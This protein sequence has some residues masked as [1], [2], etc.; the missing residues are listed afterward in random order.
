[1]FEVNQ[2]ASGM[3][4]SILIVFIQLSTLTV[5]SQ[6]FSGNYHSEPPLYEFDHLKIKHHH[7]PHHKYEG[8]LSVKAFTTTMMLWEVDAKMIT[9]DRAKF[10]IE[11]F[12][13]DEEIQTVYE[14]KIELDGIE[15]DYILL[16]YEDQKG[17]GCFLAVEEVFEDATEEDLLAIKTFRLVKH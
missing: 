10:F 8:D 17:K 4:K 9:G 6:F 14:F 3:K 15:E 12:G 7:S 5:F 1:M 2:I 16:G 11:K 13:E